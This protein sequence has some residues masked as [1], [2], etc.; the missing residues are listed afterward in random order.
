MCNCKVPRNLRSNSPI[1][2]YATGPYVVMEDGTLVCEQC[3]GING[4]VDARGDDF[5][6]DDRRFYE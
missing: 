2:E 3:S 6:D 5:V 4:R 1:W